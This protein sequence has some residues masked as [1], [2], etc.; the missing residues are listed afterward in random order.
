MAEPIEPVVPGNEPGIPADPNVGIKQE[1]DSL[2]NE[3]KT[4]RQEKADLI[5]SG[6]PTVDVDKKIADALLA[7]EQQ[8]ADRNWQKAQDSF[9]AKHKEFHPDNDAGGLKK[10]A[11][12]R[13]LKFLNRAGLTAVE[14]LESVLEKARILV[15]TTVSSPVQPVRVDPSI[16][17]S[18]PEPHATEG[19]K[20][21]A[22]ELRVLDQLNSLGASV[23]TEERFLKLK[24]KDPGFV[25]RTLAQT[26]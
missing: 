14:D 6:K 20:L 18:A 16:P 15:T 22:K 23:W 4:L 9:V 24:E 25:E 26:Q 12:D 3:I 17:R 10:A 13:E 1:R 7:R 8:E 5:N 21:T 11:L 19:S 2:V